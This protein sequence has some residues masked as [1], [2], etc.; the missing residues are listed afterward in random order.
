[1]LRLGSEAEKQK[2]PLATLAL[3]TS[4]VRRSVVSAGMEMWKSFKTQANDGSYRG[5]APVTGIFG[6]G[7]TIDSLVKSVQ[8]HVRNVYGQEAVAKD[9]GL[10]SRFRGIEQ[11]M[12]AVI[13]QEVVPLL[14]SRD[15]AIK[16]QRQRITE[17]NTELNKIL[18]KLQVEKDQAIRDSLGKQI[19]NIQ[20]QLKNANASLADSTRALERKY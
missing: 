7:V 10:L 18:V 14:I 17:L 20:N 16:T 9:R 13:R 5:V 1:M 4:S 2:R 3:D 15:S 8:E 11:R 19:E 12:Q 6:K